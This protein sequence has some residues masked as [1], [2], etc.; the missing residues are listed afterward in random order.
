M[1]SLYI[2]ITIIHLYVSSL[3]TFTYTSIT[4]RTLPVELVRFPS[5]AATRLRCFTSWR[6]KCLADVSR[7]RSPRQAESVW[8]EAAAG[9]R[10][11]CER[12]VLQTGDVTVCGTKQCLCLC[13]RWI[14]ER[15]RDVSSARCRRLGF[16]IDCTTARS[17]VTK[18]SVECGFS[19]RECEP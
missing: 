16:V 2:Y 9:V 18:V 15:L 11:V 7:S 14:A 4:H 8:P 3:Y 17:C 12:G 5:F 1:S 10:R 6:A 13:C 19:R